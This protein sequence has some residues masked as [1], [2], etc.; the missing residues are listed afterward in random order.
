MTPQ[1]A[2]SRVTV[3]SKISPFPNY[4]RAFLLKQQVNALRVTCFG[5]SQVPVARP[6]PILRQIK[7]LGKTFHLPESPAIAI[8]WRRDL[9]QNVK[10]REKM[11]HLESSRVR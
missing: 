2:F 1:I 9:T 10:K 11:A 7:A 6:E 8:H 4:S 3:K 5:Q